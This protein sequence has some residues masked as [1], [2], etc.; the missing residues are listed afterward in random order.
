MK[1]ELI[2]CIIVVAIIIIADVFSQK[3]TKNVFGELSYNLE[4]LKSNIDN[5][6]FAKEKI[7]YINNIWDEKFNILTCYLEHNE[8]EEVKN[9]LV[10]IETAINV[11]DKSFFYEETDRALYIMEHIKEKES[12]RIDNIL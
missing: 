2:I 12:L 10:L 9:Q 3:Y 6:E 5:K 1:K 8:L 7:S 4:E 11:E